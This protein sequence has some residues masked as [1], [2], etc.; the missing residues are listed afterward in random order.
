VEE[1]RMYD[2][3]PVYGFHRPLSEYITL[4]ISNGFTITDFEEPA[5]TKED[6]NEH[7]RGLNDADRIPW[8]LVVGAKKAS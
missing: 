7:Y 2:F 4:L 6:I 3:S 8:F 5:P 1:W